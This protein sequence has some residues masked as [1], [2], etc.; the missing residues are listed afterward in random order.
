MKDK[1][2]VALVSKIF[3]P[4][5]GGGGQVSAYLLAEALSELAEV[6]VVTSK[7]TSPTP[8]K[9]QVHPIIEN[10]TL[11]NIFEHI[12]RNEIFYYDTHNALNKLLKEQDIDIIHALNMDTIPGTI[13]AARRFKIPSVITVN[14]QWLTCPYGVMLKLKDTSVCDGD[15]SFLNA[16]KCY[17]YSSGL[18]KVL[19]PLYYPI[20]MYTRRKLSEKAD[21]IICVSDN[22]KNYVSKLYP[23]KRIIAMPSDIIESKASE[24]VSKLESDLLYVGGLGGYKGCEY[25][26]EAMEYIIK[27]FDNCRLRIVGDGPRRN[28]FELLSRSKGL[29]NNISFEGFMEHSKLPAY[30]AS[31]KIVIFPSIIPET[32]GRIAPEAMVMGKPVIA[33]RIGGIP[34]T[35]KHG[36]N[37]MIVQPKNA[38]D[39]ADA[40]IYLLKNEELAKKMGENGKVFVQNRYSSSMIAKNYLH[41]YEELL[42]NFILR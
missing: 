1:I 30:Y 25:L 41:L 19:G 35:V 13:L 22:M 33:S 38:R 8:S 32:F 21:A 11:P 36:E 39:I 29:E 37:G 18:Q 40:A 17:F 6:H 34:E 31:T 26:I 24:K 14:S 9:F 5:A 2:K 20:Q 10:R 42:D 28:E 4:N 12:T 7:G 15:C 27:E 23:S 3:S 16:T